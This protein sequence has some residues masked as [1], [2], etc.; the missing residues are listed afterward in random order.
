MY[1]FSFVHQALSLIGKTFSDLQQ[2]ILVLL[3]RF[4]FFFFASFSFCCFCCSPFLMY[5]SRGFCRFLNTFFF[6]PE[7]FNPGGLSANPVSFYSHGR[8]S[9]LVF[10]TLLTFGTYSQSCI[11]LPPFPCR[12]W[13]QISPL[14]QYVL[15]SEE[16]LSSGGGKTSIL[17]DSHLVNYLTERKPMSLWEV[18]CFLP[19]N[20]LMWPTLQDPRSHDA[21]SLW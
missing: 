6:S 16:I 9:S 15:W 13:F 17:A 18:A 10:S 12:K 7:L 4:L 3:S 2:V 19:L 8:H 14:N 21:K 20:I 1:N 5:F 11:S